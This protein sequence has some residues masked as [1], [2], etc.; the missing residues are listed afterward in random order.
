MP[1]TSKRHNQ[2]ATA[3]QEQ[4]SPFFEAL[5][6]AIGNWQLVE[7]ELFRVY[8]RLVRCENSGVASAAFHSIIGFRI[9]L[10]ITDA[11][12]EVALQEPLLS[13]WRTLSAR[14]VRQSKR[15]NSLAHF[16]VVY[17]VNPPAMAAYGPFLRP[18]IFDVTRKPRAGDQPIDIQRIRRMGQAFDLLARSIQAFVT[19]LPEPPS[20]SP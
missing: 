18:S 19:S 12:A 2:S 4:E 10:D 11:A 17:G 15:R 14:T 3:L 1:P 20:S 7:M 6:R 9:R 5:G 13:A 16:V 8:E